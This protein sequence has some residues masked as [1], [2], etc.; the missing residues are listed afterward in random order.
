M[1]LKKQFEIGRLTPYF[2]INLH[3]VLDKHQN[4]CS[5]YRPF[6]IRIKIVGFEVQVAKIS[7]LIEQ[8]SSERT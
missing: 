4:P 3:F 1:I 7:L 5:S 2:S 8:R 6:C